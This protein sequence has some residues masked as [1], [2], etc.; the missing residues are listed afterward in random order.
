MNEELRGEAAMLRRMPSAEAAEWLLGRYSIGT[1]NWDDALTL[2]D[3]VSLR[4]PDV[5]RLAA[6]YLSGTCYASDRPY[7]LFAKL[8]GLAGLLRQLGPYRPASRRDADLLMHHLQPM[9]DAAESEHD[10]AAA[11]DFVAAIG[12]G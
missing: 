12:I 5:Q 6:D 10:R 8:L 11:A 2:L 3:H 4:K 1:T 9:L 7:R